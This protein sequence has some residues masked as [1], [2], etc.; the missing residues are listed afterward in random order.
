MTTDEVIHI[1]SYFPGK[2]KISPR[3]RTE[4]RPL[5]CLSLTTCSRSQKSLNDS[6][7]THSQFPCTACAKCMCVSRCWSVSVGLE[8]KNPIK[9]STVPVLPVTDL[10]V[11]LFPCCVTDSPPALFPELSLCRSLFFQL[12]FPSVSPPCPSLY[13]SLPVSFSVSGPC[14]VNLEVS[15]F[16]T[17]PPAHP[18][19]MDKHIGRGG[20]PS[21]G[22]ANSVPLPPP[23][24]GQCNTQ[25]DEF[26]IH[27]PP[28]G[29]P[30]RTDTKRDTVRLTSVETFVYL[31]V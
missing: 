1:E 18:P 14:L 4:F 28:A 5:S 21:G 25:M 11:A 30:G 31:G 23:R 6:S 15:L 10:S 9:I 22:A 8:F 20:R 12:V 13:L 3:K 24:S 17:L 2:R 19:S 29:S 16:P 27:P 7:A 26:P